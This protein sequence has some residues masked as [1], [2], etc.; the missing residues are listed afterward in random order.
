MTAGAAPSIGIPGRATAQQ[1]TLKIMKFKLRSEIERISGGSLIGPD[2]D[3]T[4]GG[5]LRSA[6]LPADP[7]DELD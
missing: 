4:R 6:A 2:D 7:A 5:W 3:P 1:K